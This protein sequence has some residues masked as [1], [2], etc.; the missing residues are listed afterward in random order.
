VVHVHDV[1]QPAGLL[2]PEVPFEARRGLL[3]QTRKTPHPSAGQTQRVH[4]QRLHLHRLAD[5]RRHHPVAHL[6]VHPGELHAGL[7]GAQ[8]AVGVGADAVPRAAGVAVQHRIHRRGEPRVLGA[9]QRPPGAGGGVLELVGG[10]H[11]PERGIDGVELRRLARVR[12]AVRQHALRDAARPLEQDVA[13]RLDA[14][15]GEA[16]APHRD[17]GVAPPVGEPGI[18]GE[19][20]AAAVALHEVG[21]GGPFEGR[22]EGGAA[23]LL[24]L[25]QPL[26]DPRRVAALEHAGALFRGQ[27]PDGLALHEVE[28]EN[29]G[30][31]EV[32]ETVETA[33]A[34]LLVEE[35]PVPVGRVDVVRVRERDDGRHVRIG[36]PDL[37]LAAALGLEAEGRV[38]VVEGV[39]VAAREKRPHA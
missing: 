14:A 22:R 31:G 28:L 9:A 29:A 17:E 21:V 19:Q 8:Q 33:L 27:Q 1:A 35:A 13:R 30:R 6:G 7:A 12:E 15:G 25:A 2:V 24:A 38:L 37:A 32:L 36:A 11:E 3:G 18:A 20:R 34:L 16:E 23:L 39:V 4:P 10:H 26:R 5:A